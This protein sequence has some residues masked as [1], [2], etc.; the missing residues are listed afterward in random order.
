[1]EQYGWSNKLQV[2][3]GTSS[4]GTNVANQV[5]VTTNSYTPSV[6]LAPNTTHYVKIIAVG[7][8]GESAGC[9]EISFTTAPPQPA[10]D[11]CA[12]AVTLTVNPDLNCGTVTAGYTLGATDS[13]T[14]PSPCYGDADDDVWFKFVATASTHKI[15]LLNIT[16][17]GS[18]TGDTDTYFQVFSGGCGRFPVYSV[19]I[20][21]QEL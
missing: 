15:S 12:T 7:S 11:E 1:M 9:T 13:G 17:V 21:L 4:G 3:I 5:S 14:A 20:R 18:T 8:G 16:S 19:Q 10:N 2:S 6:A